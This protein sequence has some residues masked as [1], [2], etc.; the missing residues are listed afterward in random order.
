MVLHERMLDLHLLCALCNGKGTVFL[1]RE[2]EI[3]YN[4]FMGET[5]IT[6]MWEERASRS[7]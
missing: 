2:E 4:L 5:S 3:H 1:P 7:G 6:Q